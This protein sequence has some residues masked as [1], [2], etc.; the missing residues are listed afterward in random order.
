MF[1][2]ERQILLFQ[3]SS[4]M[5]QSTA[6]MITVYYPAI[7]R[8][9]P[10]KLI[11]FNFPRFLNNFLHTYIYIYMQIYVQIYIQMYIRIYIH[12]CFHYLRTNADKLSICHDGA[13]WKKCLYS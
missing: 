2:I 7:K 5:K 12:T 8:K 4:G 11:A 10:L 6:N 3:K 13:E 9:Q 1:R